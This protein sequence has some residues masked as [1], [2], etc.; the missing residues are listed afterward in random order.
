MAAPIDQAA[1]ETLLRT[2]SLIR[3]FEEKVSEMYAKVEIAGLLH[4]SIGQEAVAAAVGSL[5]RRED[6]MYSGHRAHGHALAKGADPGKLMAEIAGRAG[7][8][9]GG[10]GGSMHVAAPEVGFMTATGVVGGTIPLALGSALAFKERQQGNVAVVFFGD[11]AMN[12]GSFSESLN[13]AGL[14]K[15]PV[16]FICEN[17]GYAEFT[18]ISAHTLVER[19]SEHATLFHIPAVTV[20][21]NDLPAVLEAAVPAVSRA[22]AAEGPSLVE[23]LT[24]RLRGHYE[25]DPN[26]YR[27]LSELADWKA[28]DPIL[29][30]TAWA[31]Q[32]KLLD[33]ATVERIEAE[34]QDAVTRAVEFTRASA[35]AS[36]ADVATEVYA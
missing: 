3:A 2:M 14:W 6:A 27:E 33:A 9:C 1:A 30:F 36:P 4:L 21:G 31:A 13:I 5:L 28:K 32:A 29:R 8:Y 24:Y 11:G 35:P 10:K 7:G 15:L 26:K 22:R 16:V 23:C 18:P 20:D 19:A 34:A 25:G 12:S 17:N